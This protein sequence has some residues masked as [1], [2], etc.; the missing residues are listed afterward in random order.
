MHTKKLTK[1]LQMLHIFDAENQELTVIKHETI[2]SFKAKIIKSTESVEL[3]DEFDFEQWLEESQ[4][5][6][7][8]KADVQE[9][10]VSDF[11]QW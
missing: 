5:V 7:F 8:D 11:I 4:L 1:G 10:D 3:V 6:L 9:E 2:K